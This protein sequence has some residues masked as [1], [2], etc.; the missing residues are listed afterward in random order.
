MDTVVNAYISLADLFLW[1]KV[2]SD[3]AL[4]MADIPLLLKYRYQY[5]LDNWSSM[6]N[7]VDYRGRQY[8]DYSRFQAELDKFDKLVK[9]ELYKKEGTKTNE[10]ELISTYYTIFDNISISD[11]PISQSERKVVESEIN[12]VSRFTKNSFIKMRENFIAGRDAISDNIGGTDSTYNSIYDRSPLTQLFNK[13]ISQLS[14]SY[15]FQVAINAVDYI[16]ANETALSSE[17]GIDPFAFARSNA[18][19]PEIDI[20]LYSSGNLVKL[21]YGETLQTLALRMMGDESKWNEIAIANG[22]KPPYIDEVGQKVKLLTNAKGN[23]VNVSKLDAYGG[24]NKEKFYINQILILRSDTEKSVD[25]RTIVSIKEVPVSGELVIELSGESD[26]DKYKVED[27][28]YIT[29]FKPHT[30]NSNFFILIPSLS[31]VDKP[32]KPESPWFLKSKGEDEKRAGV[33]LFLTPDGDI[34]FTS[35]GDMQL[36]YGAENA[37]Q[38]IKV[39]LSTDAGSLPKHGDYGIV[40]PVGNKNQSSEQ[41]KSSLSTSIASQILNDARFSRLDFLTVESLSS[42]DKSGYSVKLGVVLAGGDTVIPISFK[43]NAF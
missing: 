39:L 8:D 34:S 23:S 30:I 13:S 25:Q 31:S 20:T 14:V 4:T 36:S 24:V 22:L 29:V 6:R 10:N 43:V 16:L 26:L 9:V 21:N 15:Q 18:N 2:Q 12:R 35:A 41:I 40:Y 32:L 5:I 1:S 37:V 27:N 33:D 3:S 28:A 7:I 19:N 17:A 11:I 42:T 38:T